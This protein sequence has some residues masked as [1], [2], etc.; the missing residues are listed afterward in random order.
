MP[1][2]RGI[3]I[4]DNPALAGNTPQP[5]TWLQQSIVFTGTSTNASAAITSITSPFTPAQF[6]TTGNIMA[7]TST[8]LSGPGFPSGGTTV[9]SITSSSAIAAAI[10]AT[11]ALGAGTGLF[12]VTSVNPSQ[13]A[14]AGNWPGYQLPPVAGDVAGALHEIP[15]SVPAGN[16][17]A[18]NRFV[19]PPGDLLVSVTAAASANLL[20]NWQG[21][22]PSWLTVHSFTCSLQTAE[23][24]PSDCANWSILLPAATFATAITIYQF[25]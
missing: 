12:T 13:S 14:F 15:L 9:A 21:P 8:L 25:R 18:N 5:A 3:A 6:A 7:G 11:T 19:L 2:I 4:L 17:I 10:N 24:V 16:L 22:T 20:Q 1:R 23:Y